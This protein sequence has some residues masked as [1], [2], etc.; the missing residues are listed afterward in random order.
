MVTCDFE[1]PVHVPGTS[2]RA[3]TCA[4]LL[5]RGAHLEGKEKETETGHPDVTILRKPKTGLNRFFL[6]VYTG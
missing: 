5:A 2:A 4:V 6:R 3:H 1:R